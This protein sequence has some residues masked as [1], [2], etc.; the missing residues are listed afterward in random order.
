MA[1]IC[2]PGRP[3]DPG[4]SP[5]SLPPEARP[6]LWVQPGKRPFLIGMLTGLA[7]IGVPA[8]GGGFVSQTLG[9]QSRGD[10][11][12]RPASSAALVRRSS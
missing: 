6:Q 9:S 11:V 3:G 12:G 7:V 2:A 8:D 5:R 4:P 1:E 10:T